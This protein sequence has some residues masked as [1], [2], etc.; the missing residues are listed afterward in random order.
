M[1]VDC[2]K[3]IYVTNFRSSTASLQYFVSIVPYCVLRP[4]SISLD[5]DYPSSDWISFAFGVFS[6]SRRVNILHLWRQLA[7]KSSPFLSRCLFRFFLFLF[8]SVPWRAHYRAS[9]CGFQRLNIL[10]YSIVSGKH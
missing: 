8:F 4:L 2:R 10:A 6:G 5:R 7:K 9:D 3:L 1:L